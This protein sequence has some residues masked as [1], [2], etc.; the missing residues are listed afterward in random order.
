MGPT[1]CA[2][3][4]PDAEGSPAPTPADTMPASAASRQPAT[5]QKNTPT[6]LHARG[7]VIWQEP[8]QGLQRQGSLSSVVRAMVL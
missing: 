7:S 3:L 5:H 6:N 1:P 4:L 2:A 8:D